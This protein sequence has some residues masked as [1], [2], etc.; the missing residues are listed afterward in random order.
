MIAASTLLD[1]LQALPWLY[2]ALGAGLAFGLGALVF[3]VV[4]VAGYWLKP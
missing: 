1:T 2:T 3:S 4:L